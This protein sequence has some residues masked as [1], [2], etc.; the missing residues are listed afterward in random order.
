MILGIAKIQHYYNLILL[1]FMLRVGSFV[2]ID[3][4]CAHYLESPGTKDYTSAQARRQFSD[5][6]EVSIS[7]VLTHGDLLSSGAG[8][9][10]RG[11]LLTVMRVLWPRWIIKLM[12]PRCGL[13][14]LIEARK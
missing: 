2:A 13:F 10:H 4:I 1:R 12:L 9:R 11:F 8:Q 7:T 3:K 6:R 5:F 14:M